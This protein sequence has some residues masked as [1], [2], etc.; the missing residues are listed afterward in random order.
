MDHIV[1][2][3]VT[4]PGFEE[5]LKLNKGRSNLLGHNKVSVDKMKGQL[6]M[7]DMT[8]LDGSAVPLLQP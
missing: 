1:A 5:I 6:N 3:P 8:L 4:K 2:K 7:N